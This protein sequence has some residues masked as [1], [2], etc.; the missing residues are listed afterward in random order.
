MN[1]EARIE[2]SA[3]LKFNEWLDSATENVVE[4]SGFTF[5]PSE[6]L[7]RMNYGQYVKAYEAY[8]EDE[9]VLLE[10]VYADFPSPI[11]Y[12]VF[13]AQEN[14]DNPHHRLDLLKSAWEVLVF[15]LYGVVVSEARH[16]RVPLKATGIHLTAYY[17]DR[18][19]SR[20]T[21]M[22]NILDYCKSDGHP[23]QCAALISIDVVSK[24]RALNQA[25][26]EF[27]HSFAATP[28][29]Q[30][31]L[32]DQLFPEMIGTL[33]TLR[34]LDKIRLFR[35]HS[36]TD[37]GP[38]LPRC[39]VFRG[40]SLDG[41]KSPLRL[42][43]EDYRIVIPYFNA[44][45]VFA[46]IE[47]DCLF[48]LSPFIHF[49]KEPKGSHPKLIIYKKSTPGGKYLYGVVGQATQLELSRDAFKDR[50][51]ELRQLVIGSAA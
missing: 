40:R 21:I 45:S 44:Q 33:R 36:V 34:T 7:Y 1:E 25:R 30:A 27:A 50:D 14:Y 43:E 24:L 35:F 29:Q 10:T 46:H 28:D 12:Y 19:A 2:Y 4:I 22:E 5:A 32:Y 31:F 16:R 6:T 51:D 17:S 23:L 48:C 11:S 42:S 37:G 9:A 15:F 18:L 49:V 47:D 26:N 20:L 8:L 13:Q 38:L 39:D 41:A 3:N